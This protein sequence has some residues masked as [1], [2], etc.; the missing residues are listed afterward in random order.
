MSII[1]RL[2]WVDFFYR[3]SCIHITNLFIIYLLLSRPLVI[4]LDQLEVIVWL[5]FTLL[6]HIIVPTP[7]S[8]SLFYLHLSQRCCGLVIIIKH[9]LISGTLNM[10]CCV[11]WAEHSIIA[12]TQVCRK[13]RL[14]GGLER[15]INVDVF[16]GIVHTNMSNCISWV[17]S[18]NVIFKTVWYCIPRMCLTPARASGHKKFAPILFD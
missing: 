17:P 13:R 3:W 2:S 11:L 4:P 7:P 9:Y 1:N 16:V 5:P 18:H 10:Y 15:K 6:I 8:L 14:K 12:F